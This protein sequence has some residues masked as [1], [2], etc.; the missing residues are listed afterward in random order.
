MNTRTLSL[1]GIAIALLFWLALQGVRA[2]LGLTF[3]PPAAI[4][5]LLMIGG[6]SILF[7]HWFSATL[8][9]RDA[10]VL[11]RTRQLEALRAATLAITSE[12]ELSDIL[13]RV[14]DLSRE[15]VD[16]RYGALGV[17]DTDGEQI[18]Q[19]ITSGMTPEERNRIGAYPRGHGLLGVI[20]KE[21]R[22]V[23]IAS[24]QDDPQAVGFPP[25][26]P[27]MH[28]LI[29]VPITF[30][31]RIFGN[32]YL[33]DKHPATA[34]GQEKSGCA[35]FSL[36]DQELLE[37]FAGQAAVAIENALL[38]RRSRQLAILQERE[39]FGMDLHDGIIQSV[40]G[41]GLALDDIHYHLPAEPVAAKSRI[42]Q[43]IRTLN[44]VIVD[45][46]N[47]ILDLRPGRFQDRDLRGGLEELVR[48]L[49]A[50]SLLSVS[51][52]V[53]AVVDL[54]GAEQTSELLHVAAEALTNVRKH[55]QA[56]SVRVEAKRRGDHLELSITDDGDGFN[57]EEDSPET[58]NGL[59]NMNERVRN[60]D[61]T[62]HIDSG[63][64]YGTRILLSVPLPANL[65]STS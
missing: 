4:I 47:Y 34:G 36:Q 62:M 2:L 37:M 44:E 64:G 29:G 17:L 27:P 61:G 10:E 63:T 50:N 14:V 32:L 30:R 28:T 11:A 51:L 8:A 59:R 9:A 18:E 43:V 41:A 13:Q 42:E 5:E 16:A 31:D 3:S 1:V 60:L 6:G 45:I 48:E 57:S 20:I 46:R 56:G 55:A 49:R 22:P 19:F 65:S 26:H 25:H 40:Y 39:R 35:E 15:L 58:S 54:V 38:S 21:R 52:D 33:T 7:W 53:D 24:M 23:R 12:S